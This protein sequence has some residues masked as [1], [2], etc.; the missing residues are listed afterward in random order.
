MN[1]KSEKKKWD[2]KVY[3]HQIKNYVKK[4]HFSLLYFYKLQLLLAFM[5]EWWFLVISCLISHPEQPSQDDFFFPVM[6]FIT[7]YML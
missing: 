3:T 4:P 2:K 7:A 5:A 6:L 1:N